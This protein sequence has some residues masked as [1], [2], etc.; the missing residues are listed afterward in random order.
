MLKMAPDLHLV[1]NVVKI[2]KKGSFEFENVDGVFLLFVVKTSLLIQC[3]E[4]LCLYQKFSQIF[5]NVNF[6]TKTKSTH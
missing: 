6:F 3:L 4:K 1:D 5:I 2:Q